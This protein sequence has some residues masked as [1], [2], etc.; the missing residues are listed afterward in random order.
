MKNFNEEKSKEWIERN[1]N[2]TKYIARFMYRYIE[3]NL[4]FAESELKRK[5]Y[6]INGQATAVLRH[7]WGL[8]KDREESDKHHA[9]D[10]VIIA[11][12]TNKNIKRVSD[13]NRRKIL[14]INN[15]IVDEQTGEIINLKYNTE[16]TIKE[17]WPKFR[18]EVE[19]RME[20]PDNNGELYSLK[21]GD[22][23]NY[24]DV[25]I[26]K[27]KPIFVSR[28]PER[29]ITGRAH[30]DTMR[31]TK[32]LK[33][34]YNF[35][36]VKKSLKNITKQEIE[37]IINNEEFKILYLSDKEMYDDIYEKMQESNF[38]ADKAFAR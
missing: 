37:L 17:P 34:G 8:K 21:Y 11:C 27:I 9:Q 10:A 18:E 12:A 3:N 32:F 36:V 33:Q 5:V 1:I 2:D 31:S 35:T 22:F 25:D 24:E 4:K 29:K 30:K 19:A 6:T 20:E 23:R 16:I 14:H 7:F 38:K 15:E 13:Y 26:S 28:M